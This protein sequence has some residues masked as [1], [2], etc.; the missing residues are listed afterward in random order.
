MFE[1][2]EE[3]N[4][5]CPA[6]V[7][8]PADDARTVSNKTTA[9]TDEQAAAFP[10]L[11]NA[12]ATADVR[13]KPKQRQQMRHVFAV[14][15]TLQLVMSN[16]DFTKTQQQTVFPQLP[17]ASWVSKEVFR[18]LSFSFQRCNGEEAITLHV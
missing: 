7:P 14:I 1:Q 3:K 18:H 15:N 6:M 12:A 16:G 8:K 17:A 5:S 11:H 10:S 13:Q 4:P 2:V 9:V